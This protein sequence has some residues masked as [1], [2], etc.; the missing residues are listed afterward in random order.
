MQTSLCS[1]TV[2]TNPT[3]VSDVRCALGENPLWDETQQCVYW[4]DIE[5][6]TLY[7]FEV[8][9]QQTKEI[10]NGPPVGGFTLQENGDLLLFR[11]NDI[12]LLNR[13]GE[14]GII[15]KIHDEGMVRFNDGIADP[16]GR[17]FAG[18]IGKTDESGGV[19]RIDCD[20]KVTKLFAGTGCSNGMGFSL[21]VK[22]FYWTCSTTRKIFRFDYD[23]PTGVLKN[24]RLFY[25]SSSEEGIPDG[26]TV[27]SEGCV[28][29]ARW[30]GAC[31]KRHTA[32][33]KIIETIHFPASNITSLIFG[34]RNLDEM[35]VT[36]A[37]SRAA[38]AVDAGALFHLQVSIRGKSEF[39]SRI[40]MSKMLEIQAL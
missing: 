13:S 14:V 34:G 7:R 33:G 39:R 32:D 21:D 31:L 28:W 10:Y 25:E 40:R 11:V 37:R 15:Q 38:D 8:T 3:I 6:G 1:K 29:S 26:L 4:T 19:F 12:A 17:I 22:T 20:G 18:T 5:A 35:F 24:R 30:G 9:S 16:N 23:Q 27:D 2:F 36:S